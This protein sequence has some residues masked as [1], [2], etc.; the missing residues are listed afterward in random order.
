MKNAPKL[1]DALID[2][3]LDKW[4]PKL[5]PLQRENVKLALIDRIVSGAAS[6]ALF[7]GL[8]SKLDKMGEKFS[9]LT[10]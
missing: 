9:A 10:K 4:N 6:Q 8:R 3:E 5:T 1:V 7:S 2:P